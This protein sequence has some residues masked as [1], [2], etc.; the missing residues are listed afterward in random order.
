MRCAAH[1]AAVAGQQLA[2]RCPPPD[3]RC[4]VVPV[5]LFCLKSCYILHVCPSD[6]R[7]DGDHAAHWSGP[8]NAC[9]RTPRAHRPPFRKRHTWKRQAKRGEAR[10][11]EPCARDAQSAVQIGERMSQ[12][13]HR[14]S[15]EE[16]RCHTGS[17]CRKDG[18]RLEDRDNVARMSQ[19]VHVARMSRCRGSR[20]QR[21]SRKIGRVHSQSVNSHVGRRDSRSTLRHYRYNRIRDPTGLGGVLWPRTGPCARC[22]RP[23]VVHD[24]VCMHVYCIRT[25]ASTGAITRHH[26][27]PSTTTRRVHNS[28]EPADGSTGHCCTGLH[29]ATFGRWLAPPHTTSHSHQVH[30][31]P[32]LHGPSATPR[33]APEA[34]PCRFLLR[35]R[36]GKCEHAQSLKS[37]GCSPNTVRSACAT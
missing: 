32:L 22:M 2:L 31:R 10:S 37:V 26:A 36:A 34:P 28:R 11:R 19:D 27:T 6:A 8:T 30:A 9:R 5:P 33:V 7:D 21:V 3:A 12:S 25:T 14:K 23:H 18:S 29:I 24:H 1:C 13:R 35:A 15:L 20:G 17:S 16:S 4:A